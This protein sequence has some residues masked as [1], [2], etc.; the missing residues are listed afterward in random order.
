MKRLSFV[1]EV[2]TKPQHVG[3]MLH[4]SN[5]VSKQIKQAG[6]NYIK[7]IKSIKLISPFML[8]S[9]KA[10][11]NWQFIA[12][13]ALKHPLLKGLEYPLEKKLWC[14]SQPYRVCSTRWTWTSIVSN[15]ENSFLFSTAYLPCSSLKM[16]DTVTGHFVSQKGL[17]KQSFTRSS[18]TFD[19]SQRLP[20]GHQADGLTK[21]C[22][23][24][25][26][27]TGHFLQ[28][29]ASPL[30][31]LLH[32]SAEGEEGLKGSV[33]ARGWNHGRVLRVLAAGWIW[34]DLRV[35]ICLK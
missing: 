30:T 33:L 4:V 13:P 20:Q 17:S 2:A 19:W 25:K 18:L 9:Q 31:G 29:V 28:P 1:T 26:P 27:V 21:N 7:L 34:M 32:W 35:W 3:S 12:I 14:K 22:T 16:G 8:Y 24:W 10:D 6:S 5:R 23:W 15:L 11:R